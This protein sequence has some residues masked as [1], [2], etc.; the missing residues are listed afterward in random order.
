MI[1][2]DVRSPPVYSAALCGVLKPPWFVHRWPTVA[3]VREKV[4]DTGQALGMNRRLRAQSEGHNLAA[5]KN[6]RTTKKLA[7]AMNTCASLLSTSKLLPATE[8]RGS[9]AP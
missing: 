4:R 5:K 8:A 1:L 7:M 2:D 6:G 9:C 3:V